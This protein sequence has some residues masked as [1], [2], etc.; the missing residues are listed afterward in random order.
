MHL[1]A[2]KDRILKI[3]CTKTELEVFFP[4][5]KVTEYFHRVTDQFKPTFIF[6][7]F[8]YF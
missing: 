8:I 6:I 7:L 5:Y 3:M 4:H 1:R 2:F